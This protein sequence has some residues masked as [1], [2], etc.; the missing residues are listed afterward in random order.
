[1]LGSGKACEQQIKALVSLLESEMSLKV[2]PG[3]VSHLIA[4]LRV[5]H[6]LQNCLGNALCL[7]GINHQARAGLQNHFGHRRLSVY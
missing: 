4:Q 7:T 5:P 1:M 6:Q 2:L 3:R